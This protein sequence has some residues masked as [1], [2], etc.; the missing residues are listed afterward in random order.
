VMVRLSQAKTS[1]GDESFSLSLFVFFCL[2]V[3]AILLPTPMGLGVQAELL[4]STIASRM[5]TFVQ[6]TSLASYSLKDV[7]A[8]SGFTFDFQGFSTSSTLSI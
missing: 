8:S 2:T 6:S 3:G 7:F 4:G 5:T 1:L